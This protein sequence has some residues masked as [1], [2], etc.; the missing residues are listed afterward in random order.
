MSCNTFLHL[1]FGVSYKLCPVF[2]TFFPSSLEVL[3]IL[4][5]PTPWQSFPVLYILISKLLPALSGQPWWY[6]L[7]AGTGSQFSHQFFVPVKQWCYYL[8]QNIFTCY[9]LSPPDDVFR[10]SLREC[11]MRQHQNMH[12]SQDVTSILSLAT[13]LFLCHGRI[14][15]WFDTVCCWQI[16]DGWR[17]YTPLCRALP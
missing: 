3:Y 7:A 16:H 1:F 4:I 5:P 8:L 2:P 12:W 13:R 11:H 17:C 9:N 10:T 15:D 14:L 6:F